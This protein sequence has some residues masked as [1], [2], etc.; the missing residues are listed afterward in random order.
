MRVWNEMV[1]VWGE[2]FSLPLTVLVMVLGAMLIGVLWFTWPSWFE[3]L[4]RISFR[5]S[6]ERGD[7][8]RR[9][10]RI[11]TE[12][13][14]DAVSRSED[15]LPDVEPIVFA[16]LADRLAAQG[17]FAEAVRERLRSMVRELV[18][19]G[20]ISHRPGWTVTELA[21]EAGTAR[22]AVAPPVEAASGIFSDIWYAKRPALS[23]HD[24][25]MRGLAQEL[26]DAMA[27]GER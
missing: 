23:E 15:E 8:K 14:L 2:I 3:A 7:A 17:R 9:K 12:D 21:R 13:E 11:V 26:H 24:T 20:V 22:P 18:D 19:R 1:A 27:G 16:A 5:R 6:G 10:T 25:R 4:R